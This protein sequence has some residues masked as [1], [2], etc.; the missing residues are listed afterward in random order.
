MNNNTNDVRGED[1]LTRPI[2][3]RE[4]TQVPN[5]WEAIHFLTLSGI[6]YALLGKVIKLYCIIS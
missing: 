2:Y 4:R 6:E 1:L 5:A 3:P